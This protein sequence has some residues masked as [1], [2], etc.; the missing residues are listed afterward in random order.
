[1]DIYSLVGRFKGRVDRDS[2][3]A[4]MAILKTVASGDRMKWLTPL[5]QLPSKES[6]KKKLRRK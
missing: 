5:P 1:M 4:F 2:L 3:Y 6:N